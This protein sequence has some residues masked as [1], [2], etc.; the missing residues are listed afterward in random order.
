[1][2]VHIIAEAGSNYNGS[3][4]LGRK[5]NA[6]AA[7]AG[8]DSVKYQIIFTDALY[9]PG[10]YAYGHYD[11]EEVR[12]IRKAGELR[13][14]QWREL[15]EDARRAGIEF[16]ASVFDTRGLDI[17]CEL[18]PPYIKTASC[19]LNNLRFLRE[20]A[21]RGRKMVVSTGMSSL[22][23]I[24][25]A[26]ATLDKGGIRGDKLVLLHCVSAYPAP[27]DETNLSFLQTL[28]SAF[29]TAV[30]FSDH[31]LG[32]EAA[33]AA[34]A[35]GASW[36]EKHFTVDRSLPGFD[37]KHSMEPDGLREYVKAVRGVEASM[38]PRTEK[39]GAAE[40]YTRQRARRGLYVARALP[41]GHALRQEDIVALRPESAYPA[42]ALDSLVGCRLR[43]DL[44]A[45]EP[46]SPAVLDCDSAS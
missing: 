28:R 19:D 23:D 40:A 34:V 6:A 17:L 5:L 11:I 7:A 35:L 21:E 39:I 42:D 33:C 37:H 25:K 36:L 20:V 1:M 46:L 10:D 13:A 16:S 9:R 2:T 38:A 14:E 3:V 26:V 31:T 32:R 22:Q 12:R 15:C 4:A 8:A 29:G 27:L 41:S 30:G 43:R 44:N 18:D 45:F 24:E